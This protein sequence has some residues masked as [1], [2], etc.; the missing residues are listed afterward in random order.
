MRVDH[1]RT[2]VLVSQELLHRTNIVTVLQ[3]EEERM[4]IT[5]CEFPDEAPRKEAVWTAL[6]HFLHANPTDVVVLPEMPFCD[7]QMFMTKTIDPRVWEA[8]VA[9]HDTMITQF[10]ALQATLV[11]TS[12]PVDAQGKL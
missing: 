8:A 12:R 6:V 4:K 7:W 3:S 10:A 1:S 11:L 9:I 2:D 5:V